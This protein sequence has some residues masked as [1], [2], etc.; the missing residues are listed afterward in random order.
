MDAEIKELTPI[1]FSR[2]A[3]E[4][5]G[6]VKE[7][8]LDEDIAERA[9]ELINGGLNEDEAIELAEEGI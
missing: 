5:T 4:A 1:P 9:Q 2:S 7:Y 3:R 8:D 6:Q